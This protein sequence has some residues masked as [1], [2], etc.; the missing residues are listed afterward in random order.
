[1]TL[2]P[3]SSS[4]TMNKHDKVVDVDA[5]LRRLALAVEMHEAEVWAAAFAAAAAVP[6][7]PLEIAVD[8]CATPPL[9]LAGAIASAD[10]NRVVGLGV[11]SPVTRETISAIVGF[12]RSHGRSTFRVE[13]LPA[14]SPPE[15]AQW[16]VDAGLRRT[17]NGVLKTWCST[18]QVRPASSEVE[19]RRLGPEHRDAVADLNV[20]AWGAWEAPGLLRT[21][22]GAT[23]GTE[24]FRHYGIF[25]GDRL[26]WA[27][28][29][30]VS[31]NLGWMGFDAAHPRY[32]GRHI[33]R[34]GLLV[35]ID[36]A[37]RLGC[38]IV[39]GETVHQPSATAIMGTL[40]ER[41]IYS[42]VAE[43]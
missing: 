6:G 8:H 30:R 39:H 19:I 33:S 41:E 11:S 43:L 32:R 15:L 23:V 25:D 38:R 1:V 28:A 20:L 7:N 17:E 3:S 13:L 4:P 29:L 18:E 12:F 42:P 16:L 35:R 34:R 22:F 40:Y 24:G 37:R 21:W 14:T 26:V 5:D 10:I 9:V 27:G 36:E 31:G 2:E